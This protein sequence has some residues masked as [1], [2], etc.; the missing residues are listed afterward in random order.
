MLKK[1]LKD[2]DAL[3]FRTRLEAIRALGQIGDERAIAALWHVLETHRDSQTR[4]TA[5]EVLAEIDHRDVVPILIRALRNTDTGVRQYAVQALGKSSDRRAVEALQ[6]ILLGDGDWYMRFQAA[7]GLGELKV[8]DTIPALKLALKREQ[9]VVV[10]EELIWALI[11][12]NS[13]EPPEMFVQAF[14]RNAALSQRPKAAYALGYLSVQWRRMDLLKKAAANAPA[15]AKGVLKAASN[16]PA[17]RRHLHRLLL[18]LRN[19]P[20][21]QQKRTLLAEI[22]QMLRYQAQDVEREI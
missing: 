15:F 21:V 7:K 12:L 10:L 1:L 9:N 2:L 16:G 6:S 20:E 19:H 3:S 13:I 4:R 8:E 22:D 17:D 18:L 11:H 14:D 5:I